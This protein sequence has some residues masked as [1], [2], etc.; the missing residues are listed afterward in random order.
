M[1]LIGRLALVLCLLSFAADLDAQVHRRALLI[2]IDDYSASHFTTHPSTDRD[3]PS[4]G[5]AVRDARMLRELLVLLHGFDERDI[6]TLTDQAA[7]REA[8]LRTVREQLIDKM[9]KDDVVFF[10]FA[11][12]GSQVANSLS[13]EPDKL[14][15]SIVP[16][17]SRAGAADIRD[18]ELRALFN[19]ILDRGA[20]LTVMLDNC[21]SGSGARGLPS[22]AQARGVRPDLRDVRDGAD[23]GPPPEARGAFVLTATQDYGIALETRDTDGLHGAFSLAWMKAM[24]DAAPNE[25]AS[26]TFL[27]AQARMRASMPFQEPVMAGDTAARTRPFLGVQTDRRDRNVV[28]VER[29]QKDGTL[30]LQ[31]GWANGLAVGAQLRAADG[32]RLTITAMHGLGRSEARIDAGP[33]AI[34]PGSLLEVV[35]WAAPPGHPLRA[36]VPRAPAHLLALARR[37][38]AAAN[39]RGIRWI[40][41]PSETTPTH[42]LRFGT[43]GWELINPCGEVQRLSAEEALEH[44]PAGSSLFVQLPVPASIGIASTVSAEEADYI[45]AGR[46]VKQRLEYAWVRP[47]VSIREQRRSA[48]PVRSDWIR[49]GP[50]ATPSLRDTLLRLRRI[51]AWQQLESPPA[52]RTPYR[53]AL[54]DDEGFVQDDTV[55]GGRKYTLALRTETPP[56][57]VKPRFFYVFVVDRYGKSYLAFPSG[58]VENRFPLG[59]PAK[60]IALDRFAVCPPYGVDTYFLLSTEEPLPNPWILQWDGVRKRSPHSPTPL[61][62]LLML[63]ASGRR[64]PRVVTPIGWS[65]ERVVYQ[66]VPPR[67]KRTQR[68]R[69]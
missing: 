25:P 49:N 45:L 26:E 55:I 7:T 39:E 56:V 57:R 14:D 58:A 20:Q 52:S 40:E 37:L 61:E 46:Y 9:S 69:H 43:G 51:H 38:S 53:L 66:S 48:L 18:K 15:E 5:G 42:L 12:H 22:G 65:I 23:A 41:D 24:R 68:K 64:A 63:T 59:A 54:R 28:G 47:G 8:I 11:G 16:A 32:T 4:L 1:P 13:T 3:W 6:I 67:V 30:L 60:E 36:C 62:Q 35:G 10:Y 50:Q 33:G 17:D 44:V 19:R 29:S 31:G 2:G 34:T 27:R 21:H